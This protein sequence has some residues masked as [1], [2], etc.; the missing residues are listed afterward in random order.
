MSRTH[1]DK[2]EIDQLMDLF[3]KIKLDLSDDSFPTRTNRLE[4]VEN[5]AKVLE[6]HGW[7]AIR[8]PLIWEEPSKSEKAEGKESFVVADARDQHLINRNFNKATG[9]K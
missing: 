7:K 9:G 1:L 4:A 6:I 3:N 2:K 8:D 5:M